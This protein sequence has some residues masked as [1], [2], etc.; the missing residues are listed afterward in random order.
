MTADQQGTSRI[1]PGATAEVPV[2]LTVTD[3]DGELVRLLWEADEPSLLDVGGRAPTR[4]EQ[5]VTEDLFERLPRDRIEYAIDNLALVVEVDNVEEIRANLFETAELIRPAFTDDEYDA[6]IGLYESL[7]D[8]DLIAIV[9]GRLQAY[10]LLEGYALTTDDVIE[11]E[12]RLAN[13]LGGEPFPATTTVRIV[14]MVDAD[15]CVLLEQVSTPDPAEF[16]RILAESLVEAGLAEPED[17]EEAADAFG[18]LS[19]ET[20]ARAQFDFESG[21]LWRFRSVETVSDG[22][23][24]ETETLTI[25]DVTEADPVS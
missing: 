2:T 1:D 9:T 16:S 10:H 12:D 18:S 17:I 15:G 6:V 3:A 21:L 19:I 4:F 13:F 7:S 22:I 8:D 5:N 20:V 11:Y 24:E 14:E 25:L 23:A